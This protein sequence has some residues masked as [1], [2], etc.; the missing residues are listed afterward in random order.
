MYVSIIRDK[1]LY[2]CVIYLLGAF[3][4][5]TF[6]SNEKRFRLLSVHFEKKFSRAHRSR[7]TQPRF[8]RKP[9]A[10]LHRSPSLSLVPRPSSPSLSPSPRTKSKILFAGVVAAA[11]QIRSRRILEMDDAAGTRVVAT[12][13]ARLCMG[14]CTHART[15]ARRHART[16]ARLVGSRHGSPLN[17]CDVGQPTKETRGWRRESRASTSG[18]M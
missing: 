18:E 2:I 7:G 11:R 8:A 5:L 17:R 16:H 4:Y 1:A 12:P 10:L 9:Y 15:H 6:K 3:I 13:R 14:A